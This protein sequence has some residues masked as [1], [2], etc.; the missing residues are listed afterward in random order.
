MTWLTRSVRRSIVATVLCA[1]F[2]ALFPAQMSPANVPEERVSSVDGWD[3]PAVGTTEALEQPCATLLYVGLRGSGE[4]D[5]FGRMGDGLR[6]E[7]QRRWQ[8]DGTVRQVFIDYPA[9]EVS[10]LDEDQLEGLLLDEPMPITEYMSSAELGSE[11]L[12]R[13]LTD[14]GARCPDE[15]VVIVGYSQGAQAATMALATREDDARIAAVVLIGNPYESPGQNVQE[16]NGSIGTSSMGLTAIWLVLRDQ[17]KPLLNESRDDTV[18]R[19][20]Q[21]IFDLY[22][23]K[24]PEEEIIRVLDENHVLIPES[25]KEFTFSICAPGDVVCDSV[26]TM[27]GVLIGEIEWEGSITTNQEGHKSYFGPMVDETMAAV[28]QR[29][30][31][32]TA[33]AKAEA[34]ARQEAEARREIEGKIQEF[35]RDKL[36]RNV[37]GRNAVVAVLLAGALGLALIVVISRRHR[38]KAK[39]NLPKATLEQ[40]PTHEAP[41]AIG[42]GAD[43]SRANSEDSRAD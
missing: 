37:P 40:V 35:F 6:Q 18:P 36:G 39:R 16:L 13:V 19:L 43:P 11:M 9:A 27:K 7:V 23:E 26:G 17:V 41:T 20:L 38:R 34:A 8:G 21:A 29:I 22:E 30:E 31:Q 3:Q 14:S 5:Q 25:A 10:T 12:K 28:N 15:S 2:L 42:P 24:I 32:I 33:E 4:K 1:L